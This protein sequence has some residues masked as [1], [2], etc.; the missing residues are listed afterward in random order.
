VESAA[1][2]TPRERTHNSW[3]SI[4]DALDQAGSSFPKKSEN[5]LI[6]QQDQMAL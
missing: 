6:I 2:G 4:A 5:F 3:A 1:A